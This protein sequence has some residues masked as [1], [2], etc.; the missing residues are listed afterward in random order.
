[1][2]D[3]KLKM[4]KDVLKAMGI[5]VDQKHIKVEKVPNATTVRAINDARNGKVSKVVSVD[6]FFKSI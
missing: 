4:V 5:S 3:K 2:D 6:N 1:M